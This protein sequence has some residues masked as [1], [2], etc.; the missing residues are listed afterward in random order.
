M[1]TGTDSAGVAFAE[2]AMSGDEHIPDQAWAGRPTIRIQ[3]RALTGRV[4]SGPEFPSTRAMD[5]VAAI[6][7]LVTTN[8]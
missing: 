5:L 7:N 1:T 8:R 2:F 6:S 4:S 3:E